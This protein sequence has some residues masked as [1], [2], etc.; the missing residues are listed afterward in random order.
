MDNFFKSAVI[1]V[2][3]VTFL[4]PGISEA[5]YSEDV[6]T[7]IRFHE[8]DLQDVIR[9]LSERG[10]FNIV[11]GPKVSG[12]VTYDLK[13]VTARQ[14]LDAALRINGY[15]IER[16]GDIMFV[17]PLD[18]SGGQQETKADSREL[19]SEQQVS[20]MLYS[21]S[22]RIVYSDVSEMAS[23][24]GGNVSRYG[25]V[26]VN[27]ANN[28]IVVEDTA[29]RMKKIDELI[30]NL[31]VI[32]R[33]VLI[34]ARILEV[35]LGDDMQLGV[36]W[37][38]VFKGG[39]ATY[40]LSVE[41]FARRPATSGSSGLFFEIVTP[42]FDMF[43]NALQEKGDLKTLATPRLLALDNREAEIII[44]GRLGFRVTTTVNQVTTESI[45]FLDVGTM[46][47]LT[48]RISDDGYILLSIH[49][50]V[51]EGVVD[52]G[53]P[54][55]TTTEVTTR[56]IIKDGE[57]IF[58]GGLIRDRKEKTIQQVPLLGAIPFL[59]P[60]FRNTTD[61]VSRTETVV[62][63]TPHIVDAGNS[64]IIRMDKDKLESFEPDGI[65]QL[66]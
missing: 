36:D 6:L 1:I 13:N 15:G 54:S 25:K 37:S 43:L 32:P 9:T 52:Q 39:D 12:R 24:V 11:S 7:E 28:V 65:P 31:D 44:G 49:P 60:L 45:E 17:R 5:V 56:V 16:I 61:S 63:I 14:A 10:G 55:E 57:S 2:F 40:N 41:N 4:L 35:R 21:K 62:M 22:Y 48:P 20:G 33:Q 50:E 58:I 26:T 34:E 8:A 53:L 46:L 30:R 59:G 27:K 19:P 42:H 23:A 47:K 64:A 51:S 3:A 18:M 66:K 29:E 38:N